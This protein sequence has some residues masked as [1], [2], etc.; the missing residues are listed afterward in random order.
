[1]RR[2]LL[3]IATAAV[4]VSAGSLVPN[5]AEAITLTAPA[6]VAAAI[7]DTSTTDEVRTVCRR[8]YYGRVRCHWVPGPR[9]YGPRY[10]GP[11]RSYYGPRRH[12][13]YRRW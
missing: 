7:A 13:G 1:M 12:W 10:W 2:I 8:G 5:R 4:V 9:F 3:A 6:G 11:R